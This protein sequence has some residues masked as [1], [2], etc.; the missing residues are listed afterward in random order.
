M[1]LFTAAGVIIEPGSGITISL[2][3]ACF[4]LVMLGVSAGL[5]SVPLEAYIQHRS[6]PRHRGSVLAATNF[7]V[8][9]GILISALAFGFLR[10]PTF[11]GSLDNISVVQQEAAQLTDGQREQVEATVA[12]FQQMWEGQPPTGQDP[13]LDNQAKAEEF[14]T[15][16]C[17]NAARSTKRGDFRVVVGRTTPPH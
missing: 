3:W 1:L 11:D 2:V 6:P 17:S 15:F 16:L 4:L 9:S 5:F 10:R 8:F 7:L 13:P 14:K 12:A